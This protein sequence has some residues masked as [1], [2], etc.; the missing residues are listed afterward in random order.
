[1]YCSACGVAVTQGLTYCNYC[2]AKLNYGDSDDK[3]PDIR[4]GG[5]VSMMVIT[6]VFGLFAITVFMGMMKAVLHFEYGPLV[7]FTMLSFLIMLMLEGIFILLLF[8]RKPGHDEP[9]V[10]R[11]NNRAT[12]KELEAQSRLPLESVPSVTENTTRAFDPIYSKRK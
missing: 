1:M 3:P 4:P 10:T 11:R 12:T 6:F 8:R 5:L 9:R 7:A 2:G